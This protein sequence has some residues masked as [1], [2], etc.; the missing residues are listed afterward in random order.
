MLRRVERYGSDSDSVKFTELL[1]A[2]ELIVKL[3]TAAFIA[4]IESDRENHRYRLLHGLVRADGLGDWARALDETLSGPATQHLSSSFYDIR[5]AF[6]ERLN[7]GNWQHEAVETLT[8]ALAGIQGKPCVSSDRVALRA[9]FQ[10]FAELRNKSRGHGALTPATCANYVPMLSRSIYLLSTRSPVFDLPW[11]YLHRNL[12]GKYRVIPLCGDQEYFA[13][14]KTVS[15][16]TT[17]EH[18]PS[19]VYLF[20]GRSRRVD[21]VTTDLDTADFFFPNGAFR[22]GT[23]ELHSLISDSRLEGDA[24]PYLAPAT[25]RPRSE[26]EGLGDMDV[27]HQV[28]TNLPAPTPGYVP[29]NTLQNEVHG[30]LVN[31]RHPIV[32]LV[33]RGGIG[34]TSLALAILHEIAHI[35]RYNV[36]VWFSARDVDLLMS[37]AKLVQPRVLTDRDIAEQYNGLVSG[38]TDCATKKSA[39]V[40]FMAAHLRSSPH[41]PTLFVFDNFET[42]RSPVDL[43]KWIDLNI[44]LPN[45]ALITSRFRDFKADYPVEVS[46]M[47][48]EEAERLTSQTIASLNIEDLVGRV[49]RDLIIDESDRHPYVM[50][51]MLGEIADQRRFEKPSKLFARKD[52]ILEALFERTFASLSPMAARIFMTLSSWR[53]LVP[54]LAVEAAVL[55]SGTEGGDPEGAIDQLVRMSLVERSVAGDATEVLEVPLTSALF[56]RRKLEVSP[57]RPTIE[58]DVRF[59]QDIGSITATGLKD[60]IRARLDSYFRRTARRISDGTLAYE[61]IRP[62]LEF[63]G[64][65][66]PPAWLLLSQLENEIGG[67]SSL[68]KSAYYVRRFLETRP[69]ADQA[70]IAWRRLVQLYQEAGDAMGCCSAFLE[71]TDLSKPHLDEIS[72]VAN[73]VNNSANLKAEMGMLDRRT[74][75]QPLAH[76]M[77]NYLPEASATDLSRLAWLYLHCGDEGRA[78]HLAELGIERDPSNVHCQR[79]VTKL[80]ENG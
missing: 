47:E 36:I 61:E 1:Y 43:F 15:A 27:L 39:A 40:D 53:S 68:G 28:F 5:R 19:G 49:E 54:Q 63:F 78:M 71:A 66:Y 55:R 60:G 12:S 62:I 25:E 72:A 32:T 52:D 22:N 45:K 37:G 29:R 3:T 33:G 76:L 74:L 75:L 64:R 23:Y 35:D 20:T 58:N 42:V 13:S 21:L 16:T 51:I 79:L 24:T 69:V 18:L 56:G 59:L 77:E 14:L 67:G 48:Q 31:D 26:T 6:T 30:L 70:R 10:L 41:G 11:A 50:K 73:F 38:L 65:S 4:A 34:K 57:S 80:V 7:S 8:F 44:R 17:G 2:G 9:W 46:G